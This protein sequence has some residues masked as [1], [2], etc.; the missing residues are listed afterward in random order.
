MRWGLRETELCGNDEL[1]VLSSTEVRSRRTGVLRWQQQSCERKD[2][3]GWHHLGPSSLIRNASLRTVGFQFLRK[4][5]EEDERKVPIPNPGSLAVNNCKDR[6]KGFLRNPRTKMPKSKSFQ[7]A[8]CHRGGSHLRSRRVR[9]GR[10]SATT[11]PAEGRRL[12]EQPQKMNGID[13]RE[14]AGILHWFNAPVLM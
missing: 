13:I 2:R 12:A 11:S 5:K 4:Q 6:C 9:S 3:D 1:H 7:V 14:E 8:W 10:P